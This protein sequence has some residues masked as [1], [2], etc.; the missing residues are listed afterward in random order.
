MRY[1][2]SVVI[3][4]ALVGAAWVKVFLDNGSNLDDWLIKD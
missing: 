2:S 1:V 3:A 4:L